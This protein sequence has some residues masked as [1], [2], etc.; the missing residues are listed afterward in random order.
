M[1][2]LDFGQRAEIDGA[3]AQADTARVVIAYAVAE[4]GR[5]VAACP[6]PTPKSINPSGLG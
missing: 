4:V 5:T 3:K 2:E 1:E 6:W